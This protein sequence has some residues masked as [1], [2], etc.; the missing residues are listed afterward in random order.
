MTPILQS[1]VTPEMTAWAIEILRDPAAFPMNAE[2]TKTFGGTTVL[3]RVEWHPPDD[4]NPT[5]HRGVTLY[6]LPGAPMTTPLAEGIDVS[7]Y[8]PTVDWNKVLGGGALFAFIKATEGT[9]LI[10]KFFVDHW[11]KAKA[12]GILRGAYHFFRPAQDAAAQ[13]HHFLDQLF[14][15]GELP[16]VLDVEVADNI[17]LARIQDG[18]NAFIDIVAASLARPLIYTSPGFWNPLP[19]R[20]DIVSKTDLWVANWLVHAPM[21]CKGYAS[22][23]FWQYA[24]AATV[25]GIPGALNV[26]A[27][28]FNGTLAELHAYSAAYLSAL[29]G[30]APPVP[31]P[32][33]PPP[34]LTTTLGVQQALNLLGQAPPLK[35]DGVRGPKTIAAIEIFQKKAG[36]VQDGVVGPKTQAALRA[37]L[38]VV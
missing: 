7:A 14:D 27:N 26:D 13:A 16:P 17:P 8:Q 15:P 34:D 35:E 30:A 23:T 31:P 37:V 5:T 21:A 32:T 6:Q 9:G 20:T 28:R 25:P 38:S 12:S 24:N 33:H 10:D 29:G 18:V 22:W 3:A 11:A 4:R 19:T 1:S 36:L 2:A